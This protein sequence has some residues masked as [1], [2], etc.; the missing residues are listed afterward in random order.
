MPRVE[1]AVVTMKQRD[2]SL[3]QKMNV[4]TDIVIANQS[5]RF[6]YCEE[7][8]KT[9]KAKMIT[10]A[11]KG[12]G[13]NRNIGLQ[14]VTG[15]IIMF[16]DDDIVY[17][18]GYE[19]IIEKA[20]E[21]IPDADVMIFQ[22]QHIKNGTIYAVDNHR[23]KRLHFSNGLGFGTYQIAIR[24]LSIMKANI[25]FSHLFGGGCMYS[26]GED[27]LFL[28]DCFRHRLHIYSYAAVIGD[29]IR[30][31]STWFNGY[32]E[33]FFRDRGALSVCLCPYMNRLICI[34]YLLAYRKCGEI[35][36][37][38]KY[39]LMREGAKGFKRKDLGKR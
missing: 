12:V 9:Y 4:N 15:D 7:N 24:K 37:V 22:M 21:E 5:D 8:F 10:T 25:H 13:L 18:D 1:V 3:C 35:N 23:T 26:A 36:E 33:K 27:S 14:Y 16:A 32:T 17:H 39:L 11:T 30:D 31:S 38:K 19:K 2:F 29:N 34:H 6:E 20:F 28:A